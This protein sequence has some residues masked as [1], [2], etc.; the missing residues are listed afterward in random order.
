MSGAMALPEGDQD[1]FLVVGFVCY[2]LI[3][4]SPHYP[5]EDSMVRA[6]DYHKRRG[7]NA[8]NSCSVLSQLGAKCELLA[9][10]TTDENA[11]YMQDDLK[12]SNVAFHNCPIYPECMTPFTSIIQSIASGS[13]TIMHYRPDGFPET[14]ANDFSKLNLSAYKWIHFE[15]RGLPEPLKMIDIIDAWNAKSKKQIPYSVELEKRAEATKSLISK[16]DFVFVA[17]EFARYLGYNDALSALNGLAQQV[18]PGA[19]IIVPWGEQGAMARC[20]NGE[21]VS[22]KAYSPACIVDTTGAGDTFLAATIFYLSQNKSVAESIDFG[23]RIAGAK[24]GMKG[25]SGINDVFSQILK[26]GK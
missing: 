7:G 1:T 20:S 2:D 4:T 18:K 19:T 16:G 22:S 25:Y 21:I 8:S 5:E 11:Q 14:N 15:G 9:P 6:V 10:M 24:C 17:K 26:G 13:R 3:F 12:A 23:N